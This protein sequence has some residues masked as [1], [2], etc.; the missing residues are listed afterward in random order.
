MIICIPVQTSFLG[1]TKRIWMGTG[2]HNYNRLQQ[3]WSGQ[4]RYQ[5]VH[6]TSHPPT[7][8]FSNLTEP[9]PSLYIILLCSYAQT[10]GS[11]TLQAALVVQILRP[12]TPLQCFCPNCGSTRMRTYSSRRSHKI[13]N[14]P[15]LSPTLPLCSFLLH[16]F[17]ADLS[18]LLLFIPVYFAQIFFCDRRR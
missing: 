12:D 15:Y 9:R 5:G 17:F 2:M 4:Y 3:I 8:K 11:T 18:S 7:P 6:L 1:H 16:S 13:L 14:C 10:L